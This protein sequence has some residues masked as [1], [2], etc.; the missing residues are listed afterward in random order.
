MI[1]RI[2][3]PIGMIYEVGENAGGSA[4]IVTRIYE[5]S[6]RVYRI[7]LDSGHWLMI[8]NPIEV[9]WMPADSPVTLTSS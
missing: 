5:V 8:F 3:T 4:E 7:D 6:D 1:N 2:M 9:W